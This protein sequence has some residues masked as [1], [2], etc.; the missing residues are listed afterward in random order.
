MLSPLRLSH[1][2]KRKEAN[3]EGLLSMQ[4]KLEK[5][6]A[7]VES[8]TGCPQLAVGPNKQA[9]KQGKCKEEEASS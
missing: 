1:S 4:E 9:V 3:P 2:F 8:Q 6:R 7:N 5:Q